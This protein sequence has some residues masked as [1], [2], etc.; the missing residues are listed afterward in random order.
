MGGGDGV[1][2]GI[3]MSLV[4]KYIIVCKKRFHDV[5]NHVSVANV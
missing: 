2:L 5:D 1:H 4:P 3:R